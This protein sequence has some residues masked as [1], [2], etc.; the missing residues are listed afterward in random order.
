M[1]AD[2]RPH[3]RYIPACAGNRWRPPRTPSWDTVHPRVC[4]EQR[5]DLTLPTD[6]D[7][8][9]PRVRG[10]GRRQHSLRLV[11]RYIPACAG[12]SRNPTLPVGGKT[13]HPRVCGEQAKATPCG[14]RC[15]GTS[16]R[17][18]GTVATQARQERD[19]RYIPACAGNSWL[20][21]SGTDVTPV[22]PRVCGEQALT[23]FMLSF[24][25][26][27]SPR[28]RGTGR[29]RLQRRAAGRYIPACAGNRARI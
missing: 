18:R 6:A 23:A 25:V 29:P 15:G 16:P 13:V 7:G 22:H 12:N 3:G 28:V 9:S 10:T 11:E 4:G 1:V 26:G 20:V 21:G 5:A 2:R 19:P 24:S 14:R 17:V 27:T 8:T